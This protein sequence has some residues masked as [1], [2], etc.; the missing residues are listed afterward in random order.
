MQIIVDGLLTHYER[1]GHG[2][3]L[4][5]LPGWADTTRSWTQISK[6]LAEQYDVI[7]LDIPG[8]GCSQIPPEGWGLNEYTTFIGHFLAKLQI[9][10]LY[11]FIGHSNGG[12]MAVRGLAQSKFKTQK[13]VLLASAGIRNRQTARKQ[14]L[15]MLAKVGKAI[16]APLP[17]TMK[18][19]LRGWLYRSIGSDMLVAEH[20]QESFKRVVADDVQSDAARVSLST[21]LIYGD[22]DTDTPVAYGQM[23]QA[24]IPGSRLT[25]LS[26]VGHF[27]HLDAPERVLQEVQEFLQ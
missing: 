9:S 26:G 3:T 17:G 20:M 10:E 8:F 16:T 23:L 22:Q 7:S 4:L 27:V 5:L 11:A 24:A 21:L 12:A 25:V 13:L 19:R 14:S 18:Q 15:R 2:P 6:A 1:S